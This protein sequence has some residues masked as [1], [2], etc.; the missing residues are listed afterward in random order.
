MGR[1]A[2]AAHFSR[3][4]AACKDGE[5]GGATDL[6]AAAP[7]LALAVPCCAVGQS[8]GTVA[9]VLLIAQSLAFGVA[10]TRAQRTPGASLRALLTTPRV[11]RAARLARLTAIGRD[12]ERVIAAVGRRRLRHRDPLTGLPWMELQEAAGCLDSGVTRQQIVWRGTPS[13]GLEQLQGLTV[14]DG[15]EMSMLG[16]CSPD[17]GHKVI[18]R[19][20]SDKRDC[21]DVDPTPLTNV[22]RDAIRVHGLLIWVAWDDVPPLFCTIY[23]QTRRATC[24]PGQKEE[25]SSPPAPPLRGANIGCATGKGP[26]G[27][28]ALRADV[29]VRGRGERDVPGLPLSRGRERGL[30]GEGLSPDSDPLFVDDGTVYEPMPDDWPD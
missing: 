30:G 11:R 3:T 14:L 1:V 2:F 17:P 8:S 16:H 22:R 26:R 21:L 9:R 18:A 13:H 24:V 15:P 29:T 28:A 20:R 27:R 4:C 10:A 19:A 25:S 5:V 23:V 12:V 7:L 6:A